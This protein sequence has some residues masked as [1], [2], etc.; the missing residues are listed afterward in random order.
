MGPWAGCAGW[1][2]RRA[3]VEGIADVDAVPSRAAIGFR[4]AHDQAVFRALP[5]ACWLIG[6]VPVA[7][8]HARSAIALF[9]TRSAIHD[10]GLVQRRRCTFEDRLDLWSSALPCRPVRVELVAPIG[11]EE[12]GLQA[13]SPL[14][15]HHQTH[16][17]F[18]AEGHRVATFPALRNRHPHGTASVVVL[19]ATGYAKPLAHHLRFAPEGGRP[20]DHDLFLHGVP[21]SRGREVRVRGAAARPVRLNGCCRARWGCRCRRWCAYRSRLCRFTASRGLLL[22]SEQPEEDE[23]HDPAR[24]R[25]CTS[26]HEPIVAVV[27]RS[28]QLDWD[29]A[30]DLRHGRS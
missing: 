20:F 26:T 3:N 18:V 17:A 5:G 13:R 8:F 9:V 1:P 19:A 25:A 16:E 21:L 14:E 2:L 4:A 6:A 27:G 15:P 22:A 30:D 12:H 23:S 11:P 28:R 7:A 24:I 29:R 10:S